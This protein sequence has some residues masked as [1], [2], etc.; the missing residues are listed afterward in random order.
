MVVGRFVFVG[1]SSGKTALDDDPKPR[2]HIKAS[3]K[4]LQV[5]LNSPDVASPI[6]HTA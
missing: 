4:V 2:L 1:G 3:V 6:V 5:W